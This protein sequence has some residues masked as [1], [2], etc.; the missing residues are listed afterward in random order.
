MTLRTS[1]FERQFKV[2]LV[3][4]AILTDKQMDARTRTG[5]LEHSTDDFA[6]TVDIDEKVRA[7]HS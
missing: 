2:A 6:T 4:T 3:R 1:Y 7:S 5:C